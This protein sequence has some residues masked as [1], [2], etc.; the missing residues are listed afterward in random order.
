MA[1][2]NPGR[3]VSSASDEILRR[4]EQE[5]VLRKSFLRNGEYLDQ[6]L[7]TILDCEWSEP[8]ARPRPVVN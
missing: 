3:V 1:H 8:Q 4:S 6:V 5:G 2:V 7:W